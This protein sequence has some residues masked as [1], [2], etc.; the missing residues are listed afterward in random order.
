M[1]CKD[2][3]T[4]SL[5]YQHPFEILRRETHLLPGVGCYLHSKP[6][7]ENRKSMFATFRRQPVYTPIIS[8]KGS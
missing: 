4:L 3:L 8:D 5:G 7:V 2:R 6:F 1:Y